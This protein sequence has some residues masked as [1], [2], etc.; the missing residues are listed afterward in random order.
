M[1]INQR[2][3]FVEAE[4]RQFSFSLLTNFFSEMRVEAESHDVV[5]RLLLSH[6][7]PQNG[8]RM[9]S[10]VQFLDDFSFRLPFHREAHA[11]LNL[12]DSGVLKTTKLI[13][14]YK[15]PGFI[16]EGYIPLPDLA[17]VSFAQKLDWLDS[18]A[19]T[20]DRVYQKGHSI[21]RIS[22][23]DVVL[24]EQGDI[25]LHN[26]GWLQAYTSTTP[27]RRNMELLWEA[28]EERSDLISFLV[29]VME[30][31]GLNTPN[32]A[33]S[34]SGN[35]DALFGEAPQSIL[36]TATGLMHWIRTIN[37]LEQYE[38]LTDNGLRLLASDWNIEL[39]TLHQEFF[40]LFC[41]PA[42]TYR[43]KE[44]VVTFS[45]VTWMSQRPISQALYHVVL[46]QPRDEDTDRMTGITWWEAIR[47]CNAL[48]KKFKLKPFYVASTDRDLRF[49][50]TA[51]GFRLP[52]VAEWEAA[53]RNATKYV[54]NDGISE[55]VH[56]KYSPF[57]KRD[58]SISYHN[59]INNQLTR[60]H[61]YK[62]TVCHP[63]Q[64]YVGEN[65]MGSDDLRGF[66]VVLH[67]PKES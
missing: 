19:T 36:H 58:M 11:L 2:I 14:I 3:N 40:S 1:N 67:Q 54:T 16:Q 33:M 24:N 20:F 46:N 45:T 31:L 42:K 61:Y 50:L 60:T 8:T 48:S 51:N 28:T 29:L 15:K 4:Q 12:N 65:P 18:L 25:V 34:L 53:F 37:Q 6:Q 13:Q 62:R 43:C 17:E 57:L 55:W 56:D 35:L 38:D 66:R 23:R 26:L 9:L 22:I 7:H 27:W 44:Q 32:K 63:Q 47:F 52:F 39:L 49:D 21:R 30:L 5:D 10:H 64:S 59:T 41:L